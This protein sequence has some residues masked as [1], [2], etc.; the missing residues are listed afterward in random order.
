MYKSECDI[1][2]SAMC[3]EN[4]SNYGSPNI[5]TCR[6]LS[7]VAWMC[8]T[9]GTH[10]CLSHFVQGSTPKCSRDEHEAFVAAPCSLSFFLHSR[11]VTQARIPYHDVTC[12]ARLKGCHHDD[13]LV[14]LFRT[15]RRE[16]TARQPQRLNS[17]L[18]IDSLIPR[19]VYLHSYHRKHIRKRYNVFASKSNGS[20]KRPSTQ[21]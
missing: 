19:D 9:Q 7:L 13:C 6:I 10:R 18:G 4:I 15:Q 16:E 11:D 17:H 21:G 1:K 14:D 2:S 3:S 12:S 8:N 20:A 5:L